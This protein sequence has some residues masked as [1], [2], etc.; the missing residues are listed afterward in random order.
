M[1]VLTVAIM[2]KFTYK[3]LHQILCAWSVHVHLLPA[4]ASSCRRMEATFCF[5][6]VIPY[7]QSF[8][9]FQLFR[10]TIKKGIEGG[11]LYSQLDRVTNTAGSSS[12][13][14]TITLGPMLFFT[15]TCVTP[16]SH[17]VV[18]RH[19]YSP[20]SH[21]QLGLHPSGMPRGR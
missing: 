20:G 3:L 21:A 12:Q 17:A 16:Q 7:L 6:F 11:D 9:A 13:A 5:L 10:D 1:I 4:T 8:L 14:H 2:Y 19:L 15:G 18:C